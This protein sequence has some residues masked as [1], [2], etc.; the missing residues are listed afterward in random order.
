MKMTEN[1]SLHLK[2]LVH[3]V[4]DPKLSQSGIKQSYAESCLAK[5]W[6]NSPQHNKLAKTT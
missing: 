2:I 3:V 6:G 5:S 1:E 4:P